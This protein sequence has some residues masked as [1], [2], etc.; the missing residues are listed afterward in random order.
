M[1]KVLSKRNIVVFSV[2]IVAL[3]LGIYMENRP[4]LHLGKSL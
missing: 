4:G 2:L 3:V 1:S